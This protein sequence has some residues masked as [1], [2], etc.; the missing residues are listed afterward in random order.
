MV[1]APRLGDAQALAEVWRRSQNFLAP[2]MPLAPEG[3]PNEAGTRAALVRERREWRSGRDY[4]FVVAA[5]AG[6]KPLGRINFSH[7]VRSV[8]QNSYIGYWIDA[9]H[10]R[11]GLMTEALE[12]ALDLAFGPLGLHR[13][14]AA[15]IARNTASIKLARRL[16]FRLE[17]EAKR[18]LRIAGHWEDHL[19]Y[20]MTNEEW[21]GGGA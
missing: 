7:V 10:A 14:Q 4:R 11:Q 18:Y 9:E 2:W 19:L 16:G 3:P 21:G 20:A 6:D 1:R 5:R 17:G 13:V 12:L 8:F 15:I